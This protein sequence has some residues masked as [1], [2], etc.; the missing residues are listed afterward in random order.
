MLKIAVLLFGL[1]AAPQGAP[2]LTFDQ[3][4]YTRQFV[5]TTPD[6][7]LAEYVAPGETVENWTTLVAVRNFRKLDNPAAA[8]AEFSKTLKQ[9]NP[10]ARFEIS[11]KPNGSEAIIDFLTWPEDASYAEFNVFRYIKRTAQSGLI[12]YQFAYRFTDTSDEGAEKF[13]KDRQRWVDEMTRADFP[14][15]FTK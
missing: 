10:L 14:L 4:V 7:R 3:I 13:K 11:V 8:V 6:I 9:S 5:S 12:A 2:T 15:D 1:A